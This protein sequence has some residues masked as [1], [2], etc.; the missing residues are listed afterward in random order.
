MGLKEKKVKLNPNN[1]DKLEDKWEINVLKLL[2]CLRGKV[3]TL[4][5]TK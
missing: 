2:E 1:S 5:F 4:D 3:L